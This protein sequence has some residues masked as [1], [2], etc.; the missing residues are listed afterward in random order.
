RGAARPRV[1]LGGAG[2]EAGTV[3][4]VSVA[5]ILAGGLAAC[6]AAGCLGGSSRAQEGEPPPPPPRADTHVDCARHAEPSPPAEPTTGGGTHVATAA[7]PDGARFHLLW[8]SNAGPTRVRVG[9]RQLWL[10]KTPAVLSADRSIVLSVAPRHVRRARLAFDRQPPSFARGDRA[11]RFT[12]CPEDE[13]RF[14]GPGTVG[15]RTGWAGSLL[16]VDRRLC[17]RLRVTPAAG[18]DPVPLRVPRG[19]RCAA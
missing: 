1:T 10:W 13:P 4:G 5:G 12:S 11:T 19:R 8:F 6:V 7:L 15:P 2:A 14:S 17:L 18:G 3:G 16:T 9:R